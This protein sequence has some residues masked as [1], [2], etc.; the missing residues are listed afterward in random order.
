MAPN[1]QKD[2]K[3]TD[4]QVGKVQETLRA[5]GRSTR[6]IMRPSATLRPKSGRRR[7]AR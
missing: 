1:V 5:I 4:A 2:L 6:T 7:C 3:L